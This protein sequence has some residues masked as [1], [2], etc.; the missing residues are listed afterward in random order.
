MKKPG[1]M[2]AEMLR[3]GMRKP[4]TVLYPFVKVTMPAKFRGRLK[5]YPERCIGCKL[6]MRDCPANAITIK[7]IA[8][9]Q[10]EA[11]IDCSK[12]IYCAQCVDSCPKK[13]L[14]ATGDF[15]LAQLDR[16]KLTFTTRGEPPVAAPVTTAQADS[17]K[18]SG[19]PEKKA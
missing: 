10:F 9:K 5:F 2:M 13:A 12:C 15:E 3:N 14:E 8:D 18:P 4:A 19:P 6:C 7:K 16:K 11:E 1:K 17:D